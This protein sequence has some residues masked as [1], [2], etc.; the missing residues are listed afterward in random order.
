MGKMFATANT[1]I[2]I[3][4]AID[5][6]DD[7]F[8]A[9]DFTSQTWTE[10]GGTT[11]L[12]QIGDAAELITSNQIARGRTKKAKG[13]YNAGSMAIVCDLDPEDAGQTALVAAGGNRSNFAFK[14]EFDDAPAGG[15]PSTRYFIGLVMGTPEVFEDA[16][17]AKKLNA[18][19]EV[20]SNIVKVAAAE[21]TP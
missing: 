17:S 11:N 13:T 19:L 5:D 9:A 4:T 6:Q 21:A 7:D 1:K 3:G 12:G 10:I 15:T 18:T 14:I 8:V 2:S 16:N 20:N